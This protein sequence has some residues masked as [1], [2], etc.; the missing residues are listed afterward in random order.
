MRVYRQVL[1]EPSLELDDRTW[2]RLA[3]GTPLITGAKRGAGLIVLIHTSANNA[4]SNLA[5]SGLFVDML[6]RIVNLSEGEAVGTGADRSLPR[7]PAS[8]AAAA[9]AARCRG[10]GPSP[11]PRSRRR[12]RPR[13]TRLVSTATRRR[14]G[15]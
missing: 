13:A 1:A 6:R 3:D 11:R 14:A 8:T 9:W 5:L 7:W 2:A 4:W 15:P 10:P 12:S